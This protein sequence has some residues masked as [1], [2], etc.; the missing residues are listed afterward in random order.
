ME[1]ASSLILAMLLVLAFFAPP[2]CMA[3]DDP[4]AEAVDRYLSNL[5]SDWF[6]M[7]PE[8]LYQKLITGEEWFVLDVRRPEEFAT[9]H[10]K[11]AINIPV[12]ELGK[13]TDLLPVKLGRP[14]VVYCGSGV[15]SMF[16]T[17]ALLI[18][19]YECVYNMRGGFSAWEAAGL[20]I[21]H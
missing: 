11:G 6:Q 14:I 7:K 12:H 19:G 21:E 4:V 17:S 10:L 9:G 1:W 8:V 13:N 15:R 3:A 16:A 5:P 20:P 18:L 2:S